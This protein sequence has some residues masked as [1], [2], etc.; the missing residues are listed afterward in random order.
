MSSSDDRLISVLLIGNW[1]KIGTAPKSNR[2]I[3]EIGEID[4]HSILIHD[5]SPS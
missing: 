2:K 5:R 4:T 3:V 1:I